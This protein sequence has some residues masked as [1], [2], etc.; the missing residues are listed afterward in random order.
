MIQGI[1]AEIEKR[2]H[3]MGVMMERFGVDVE[4][5]ARVSNGAAITTAARRCRGCSDTGACE[6]F[7]AESQQSADVPDFCPNAAFIEALRP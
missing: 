5:A 3:L 6:H 7:L 2:A 4:A 1:I